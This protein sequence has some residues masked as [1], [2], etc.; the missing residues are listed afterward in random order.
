M[1]ISCLFL[2]RLLSMTYFLG[3]FCNYCC[4]THAVECPTVICSYNVMV[5]TIIDAK[6]VKWSSATLDCK[7]FPMFSV[8]TTAWINQETSGYDYANPSLSSCVLSHLEPKILSNSTASTISIGGISDLG[9]AA[10]VMH[11]PILS[12]FTYSVNQLLQKRRKLSGIYPT[13][14][15]L[16]EDGNVFADCLSW[17][18]I[19][20][21]LVAVFIIRWALSPAFN[22]LL[23]YHWSLKIQI[24]MFLK[25]HNVLPTTDF[26]K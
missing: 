21:S 10:F 19:L 9:K 24:T 2:I 7:T 11:Y 20:I 4:H 13:L 14:N 1:R 15:A 26:N 5:N 8:I 25:Q 12:P 3:R 6:V 17:I 23:L 16:S 18:S 22:L